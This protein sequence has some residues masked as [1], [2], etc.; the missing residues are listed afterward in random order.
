[1]SV[2]L[3][4]TSLEVVVRVRW[5]QL[6]IIIGIINIM[7]FVGILYYCYWDVE[8]FDS[9]LVISISVQWCTTEGCYTYKQT[10]QYKIMKM[11]RGITI[12]QIL[13]NW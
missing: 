8:L 12:N 9:Y 7:L 5:N 3:V 2:H 1:M 6:G 13:V 11:K 4:I 10:L